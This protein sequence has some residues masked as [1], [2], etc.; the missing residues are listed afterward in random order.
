MTIKYDTDKL[1]SIVRDI[2]T[3]MRIS[4][5][6]A[7]MDMNTIVRGENND[8]FCE[9]ICSLPEGRA[10]CECSDSNL[11]NKCSEIGAPVSHICHAGILDTVVPIIKRGMVVGYIFIGR[12]R[13][14]PEPENVAA[15]L[16]WLGDSSEEIEERYRKLPY[17]TDRQLG[18]IVNLVSNIIFDSAVT[19][20]YDDFVETA[21]EYINNNLDKDLSVRSLCESLFVSKNRLYEAFKSQYGMTVN[22]YVWQC[23]IKR[24]KELLISTDKSTTDIALDVGI[25]NYTYFCKI[26]KSKVGISP[27]Q[28]KKI[29]SGKRTI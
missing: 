6:V 15:R 24:A 16:D 9:R 25:E 10:R 27:A 26:F 17:F 3:V 23:R 1:K 7:D 14:F 11:L 4:I 21:T 5:S 2:Q 29:N 8:E 28:F 12:I 13:P 22:D 18:S 20:Q 19:V